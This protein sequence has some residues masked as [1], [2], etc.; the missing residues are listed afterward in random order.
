MMKM[1]DGDFDTRRESPLGILGDP[2]VSRLIA[3][4]AGTFELLRECTIF[5]RTLKMEIPGQGEG[6]AGRSL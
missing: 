2:D 4:R 3:D 5:P 1:L 6:W